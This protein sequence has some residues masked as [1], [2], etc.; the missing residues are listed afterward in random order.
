MED[1]RHA[2]NFRGGIG[3]GRRPGD[4]HVNIAAKLGSSG[5]SRKSCISD[6]IASGFSKDKIGHY[7]LT[8]KSV[9]PEPVEGL[10]CNL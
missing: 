3:G 10:H 8:S 4:Q 2:S 7:I 6:G 9:R 1:F 5:D